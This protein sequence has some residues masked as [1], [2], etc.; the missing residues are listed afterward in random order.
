[1]TLQT[2]RLTYEEYLKLPEV[3]RRYE[4][5]DGEMVTAPGPST[6]HQVILAQLFFHL[7]WFVNEHG[8]GTVLFAPLDVLIE[9]EPLRTR[10]PDL[11]FVSKERS[12]ILGQI[13]EG[14][15]DLVVEVLSPGNTRGDMDDRLADYAGLGIRECWLVSPEGRTVEVLSLAGGNWK[16]V[17]LS[18]VGDTIRSAVLQGLEVPVSQI[19]VQ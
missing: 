3:R 16:R 19:F 18:G 11:L 17:S 8:L 10:Q 13:V 4:I 2:K 15:P 9:R 1:M 12:S 6:E 14:A 5:I 7:Y